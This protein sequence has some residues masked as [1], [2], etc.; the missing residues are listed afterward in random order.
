MKRLR[1]RY[2]LSFVLLTL[3]ALS[4]D[5]TVPTLPESSTPVFTL[6]GE[7]GGEEIHLIAGDDNAY[8]HTNLEM[9]NGVKVFN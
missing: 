8:M 6:D 1:H 2:I 3:V 9:V 4:C 7:F 5:K